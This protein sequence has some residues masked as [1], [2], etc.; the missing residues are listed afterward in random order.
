MQPRI[1]NEPLRFSRRRFLAYLGAAG[2]TGAVAGGAAVLGISL[3]TPDSPISTN[4]PSP[5]ENPEKLLN[6][7]LTET[8][9]TNKR[10]SLEHQYISE[11]L[12]NPTLKGIDQGFWVITESSLRADLLDL[13]WKL[14]V[15][16]IDGL[17]PLPIDKVNWVIAHNIHPEILG[18]ASDAYPIAQSIIDELMRKGKIRKDKIPA[19]DAMINAGGMAELIDYETGDLHHFSRYAFTN[20]G[21][22]LAVEETNPIRFPRGIE[23]LKKV[24]EAVSKDTGYDFIHTKIVGSVWPERAT[25]M[26]NDKLTPEQKKEALAKI[27]SSGGAIANQI[28]SENVDMLYTLI[29]DNTEKRIKLNIFDP[30]QSVV[31][32]WVLLAIYGYWR[33][34]PQDIKDALWGWNQKIDQVNKVYDVAKNFYNSFLDPDLPKPYSY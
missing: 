29:R 10:L 26:N 3:R 4:S 8:P 31:M 1:E 7:I 5:K 12:K 11:I 27:T 9:F 24:C 21:E 2:A 20:I 6:P 28:L 30:V 15:K 23:F 33:N 19:E 13:R 18:I 22:G 32:A 17:T 16:G 14:R 25:I 34:H